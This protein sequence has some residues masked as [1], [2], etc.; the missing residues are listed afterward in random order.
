MIRL[1]QGLYS[2]RKGFSILLQTDLVFEAGKSYRLDGPNGS[3]KS[4]FINHILLPRLRKLDEIHI[5]CLEQQMHMQLYALRAWGAIYRPGA[6][7]AGEADVWKLLWEDL[8]GMKDA[9]PVVIVADEAHRIVIPEELN[10]PKCLIYSSHSY[11]VA[12]CT[13]VNFEL[14]S[15]ELC[16]V[17]LAAQSAG[18]GE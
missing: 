5:I 9:K 7:I 11:S 8:E 1:E 10:R 2:V 14:Q 3:G 6:R 18:V 17:S 16:R 15:A 4:S 12:E 13:M